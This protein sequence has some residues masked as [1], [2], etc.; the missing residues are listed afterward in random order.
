MK[1]GSV[2]PGGRAANKYDELRKQGEATP[3]PAVNPPGG[4]MSDFVEQ[5]AR[6]EAEKARA[7]AERQRGRN[8]GP[9]L[10]LG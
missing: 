1:R 7:E 8:R 2:K 9:G 5:A 3:A 4:L 6:Q 10:D